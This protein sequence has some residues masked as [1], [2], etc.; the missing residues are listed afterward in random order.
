MPTDAEIVDG[1][2][3]LLKELERMDRDEDYRIRQQL[4]AILSEE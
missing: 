4:R 1:I 3:K 2:R